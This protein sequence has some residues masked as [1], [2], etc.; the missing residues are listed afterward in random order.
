MQKYDI[1]LVSSTKDLLRPADQETT[2][3]AVL[4]GNPEFELTEDQQLKAVSD[5]KVKRQPDESSV[6]MLAGSQRSRD[7]ENNILTPLP[8]TQ[9]EVESIDLLLKQNGWQP[10]LYTK[11]QAL[12]ETLKRVKGPRL[13]H[14]AT[15]GFFEPDQAYK[16][17][18]TVNDLP[19]GLEDPML[20][21]G[22]YFAGANRVLAGKAP[23]EGLEDGEL[24]AYEATGLNL[25]GTELVVLSACK[26]GLG[27]VREGEGVF[28]LRRALQEA[29]A[30]SV[31]M[32]LWSV[33]DEETR[34]VMTRFYKKWLSGIQKPE[35][36]R[37]AQ[38][39][40]RD[41]VRKKYGADLPYYWGAFIFFGP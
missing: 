35:A 17:R 21:S 37:Q 36:L 7:Q 22:L 15:H 13:L 8:G 10:E 16:Y 5:L 26:T 24:T 12:E 25:Q 2:R 14:I 31:L 9:G 19:S 39:E 32:S 23:P 20:R 40:V 4:V 33:P 18:A 41:E 11:E 3:S 1:R 6:A 29:G 27:A 38:L 30:E 34:E 28:G